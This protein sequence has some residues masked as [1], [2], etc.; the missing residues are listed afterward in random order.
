MSQRKIFSGGE[1]LVS[2]ILPKDVFTPEDLSREHKMIYDTAVDF[3]KKEILP[4]IE[5]IEEKDELFV[6]S[7]FRKTGEIGLNG[8]DIPVEYG[9]EGM[10]KISTCLVTEAMGTGASF[11]VSHSLPKLDL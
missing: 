7:L 9:G 3:V 6:R 5:H 11:A 8:I 1:F 4:N 2:E 10:D